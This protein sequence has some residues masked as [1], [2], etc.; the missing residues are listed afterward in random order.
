[1][2][3][4]RQ[5]YGRKSE[6][7]AVDHLKARGYEILVQNYRTRLGEVDI[8]AREGDTIVFVEVKARRSDRYGNA[9]AAVTWKKQRRISMVA[10]Q[11]LK[12]N[13]LTQCSARFD[14]VAIG[15]PAEAGS[16]IEIVKNAFE[17]AYT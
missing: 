13:D 6:A 14:V 1:M 7:I 15:G 5:R 10:L 12:E 9:K 16:E 8:I 2:L 17:F 3:N 11:Y 4:A